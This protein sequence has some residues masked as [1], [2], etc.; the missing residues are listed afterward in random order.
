M[1]RALLALGLLVAALP[2]PAFARD[3]QARCEAVLGERSGTVVVVSP[4]TGRLLALVNPGLA[5]ASVPPGSVFKL[6]TAISGLSDGQAVPFTCRGRFQDRPCWK[7]GGHGRLTLEEAIAQS[8]NVYF[9]QLGARVGA[10]RLQQTATLAGLPLAKSPRFLM[11]DASIGEG[12]PLSTT[13][14]RM[15]GFLSAVATDG[16]LRQVGWSEAKP[17]AAIAT[18]ST[19]AR[20]RTGMRAGVALGSGKQASSGRVAIAGKTG[21]STYLDGSN[22]TYGWFVG[23]A[24]ADKPKMAVVVMLRDANGFADAAPVGK[25]VVEAW[26]EA[27]RP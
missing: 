17:G 16:R 8:C 18:A 22:R 4:E 11:P 5:K 23:Y 1:R 3:F 24:P 10:E 12:A 25:A 13:A 20:V 15:A 19:L 14:L 21:T 6:V 7:P 27:G 26:L 2:A 9:Y